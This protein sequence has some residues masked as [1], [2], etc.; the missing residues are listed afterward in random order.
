MFF[1][2]TEKLALLFNPV[3]GSIL[4]LEQSLDQGHIFLLSCA[5]HTFAA[6]AA[7]TAAADLWAQERRPKRRR[8]RVFKRTQDPILFRELQLRDQWLVPVVLLGPVIAGLALEVLPFQAWR[9]GFGCLALYLVFRACG[10]ISNSL[11]QELRS[12]N[13]GC[14]A[15]LSV[16]RERD[17]EFQT[18]GHNLASLPGSGFKLSFA[19]VGLQG[20]RVWLA[21]GHFTDPSISPNS[22]G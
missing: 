3:V 7:C 8:A 21:R 9:N 16:E 17:S 22:A 15:G 1:G 6:L 4:L 12:K 5:L 18:K 14:A 20:Q 13:D 19:S 10:G 11:G 2:F